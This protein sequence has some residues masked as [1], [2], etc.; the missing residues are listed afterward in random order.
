MYVRNWDGK[1]IHSFSDS[2]FSRGVSILLS[3]KY[4]LDILNVHKSNDDRKLL[5]NGKIDDEFLT[6]VNVYAPNK[7]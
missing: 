3:K 6:I 2:S 7:E 4:N 5:V 1:T